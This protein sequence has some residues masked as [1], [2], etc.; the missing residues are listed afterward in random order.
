MPS[1]YYSSWALVSIAPVREWRRRRRP[2]L[3]RG[4]LREGQ[5]SFNVAG[6]KRPAAYDVKP[7]Q[8]PAFSLYTEYYLPSLHYG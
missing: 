3:R 4:C 5:V 2:R 1:L 6:K 8:E 7:S